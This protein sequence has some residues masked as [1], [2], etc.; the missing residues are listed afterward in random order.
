MSQ[1]QPTNPVMTVQRAEPVFIAIVYESAEQVSAVSTALVEQGITNAD[2]IKVEN[3]CVQ[4]TV[5][6][7]TSYMSYE[8][9]PQH[10]V[11]FA[12]NLKDSL[13]I[14]P[15]NSF[16]QQYMRLVEQPSEPCDCDKID[17]ELAALSA[18]VSNLEKTLEHLKAPGKRRTTKAS[19]CKVTAETDTNTENV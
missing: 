11:V 8:L 2:H 16:N 7:E 6:D 13:I 18:S 1:K 17:R 15:V 12:D 3:D 10:A 5:G 4:F 19:P 14:M 9:R